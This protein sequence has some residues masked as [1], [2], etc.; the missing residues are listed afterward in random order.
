M[1]SNEIKKPF[2]KKYFYHYVIR[3]IYFMDTLYDLW[4]VVLWVLACNWKNLERCR[5]W[6]SWFFDQLEYNP[7]SFLLWFESCNEQDHCMVETHNQLL[8]MSGTWS[9]AHRMPCQCHRSSAWHMSQ[10]IGSNVD[11]TQGQP[12]SHHCLNCHRILH[13]ENCYRIA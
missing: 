9:T 6:C 3:N 13:Q 11:M 1:F 2:F 8:R 5:H 4:R 7:K 10:H 12:W